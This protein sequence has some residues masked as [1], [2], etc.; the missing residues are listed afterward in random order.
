MINQETAAR[1]YKCHSEINNAE[2]LLESAAAQLEKEQNHSSFSS[3]VK[4]GRHL[5]LSWP[6][7]GND[8]SYRL[9]DVSVELGISVIRSHIA[10]QKS[11]LVELNEIAAIE[12]VK[13]DK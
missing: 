3:E 12:A 9:Y 6:S 13:S 1:I 10:K 8:F 2:K 5:Q 7:F 4:E 11:K